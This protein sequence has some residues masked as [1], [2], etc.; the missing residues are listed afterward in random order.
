MYDIVSIMSV[1]GL[2]L[3]CMQT[4]QGFIFFDKLH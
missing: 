3:D 4:Y 2:V 1:A